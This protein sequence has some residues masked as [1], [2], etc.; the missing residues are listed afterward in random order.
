MLQSSG[1]QQVLFVLW[2]FDSLALWHVGTSPESVWVC[3]QDTLW[4]SLFLSSAMQQTLGTPFR[5][6]KASRDTVPTWSSYP[7]PIGKSLFSILSD[8]YQ[9]EQSS[10]SKAK[11]HVPS[12]AESL[13]KFRMTLAL[14]SCLGMPFHGHC[15]CC[16]VFARQSLSV[17]GLHQ[18]SFLG[19]AEYFT[20]Q[21]VVWLLTQKQASCEGCWCHLVVG[22]RV[23]EWILLLTFECEWLL[24]LVC[25]PFRAVCLLWMTALLALMCVSS[26]SRWD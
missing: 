24:S 4:V 14:S 25:R 1:P 19:I 2:L 22:L 6:E 3:R 8:S 5:T 9:L 13:R 26:Y 11:V 10:L 23:W 18:G 21:Q 12:S 15:G 7:E 16:K 17:L 20:D